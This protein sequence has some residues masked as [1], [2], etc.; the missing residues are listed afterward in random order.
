MATG[1]VVFQLNNASVVADD[2]VL[3]QNVA[4]QVTGFAGGTFV[5]PST[6]TA[7]RGTIQVPIR[8]AVANPG[9]VS[10]ETLFDSAKLYKITIEE[11]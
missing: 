8:R 11:A 5:V 3:G 10:P 2:S 9:L 4:D 6:G 7:I 1:D